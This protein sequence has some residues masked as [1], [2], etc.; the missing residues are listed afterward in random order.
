MLNS[1]SSLHQQW[2]AAESM[3]SAAERQLMDSLRQGT[4]TVAQVERVRALRGEASRLLWE[5]LS[6]AETAAAACSVVESRP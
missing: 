5:F 6:E 3:A 1:L 4:S 2:R